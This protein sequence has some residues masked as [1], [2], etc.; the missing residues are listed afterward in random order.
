ML[1]TAR[2]QDEKP[3]GMDVRVEI[4]RKSLT[5]TLIKKR[6]SKEYF[7]Y[8]LDVD[9]TPCK[10]L[11]DAANIAEI[12][13]SQFSVKSSVVMYEN[14]VQISFG[15]G[16]KHINLY[17]LPNGKWLHTTLM[18]SDVDMNMIID[19]ISEGKPINFIIK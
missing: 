14:F 2:I 11:C 6:E 16:A 19:Y 17:P 5:E 1:H 7:E 18:G 9:Y 10:E 8:F 13:H 12:P 4:F 15:R 3:D